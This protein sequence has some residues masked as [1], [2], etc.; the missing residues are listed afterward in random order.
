MKTKIKIIIVVIISVLMVAG[1][2]FFAINSKKETI[3]YFNADGYLINNTYDSEKSKINKEYFN[4]NAAY[5]S[6]SEDKY[7][8]KNTDGENVV[9]SEES[10]VH[11]SDGSIMAL[12]DG[13]AID[14]DKIDLEILNYY[15]IFDG[16]ILSKKDNT[17]EINNLNDTIVFNKMLFKI[18]DNKYLLA[19]NDIVISFADGQTVSTQDYIEIEYANEDV[20]KIYNDKV[21]YKTISSNLYIICDNI[22][23]DVAYKTVSKNNIDLLA[24]VN[25][26]INANDNIEV[27]PLKD[28]SQ[29]QNDEGNNSGGSGSGNDSSGNGGIDIDPGIFDNPQNNTGNNN[30]NGDSG[31]NEVIDV[32]SIINPGNSSEN[33]EPVF[34]QPKFNFS[35]LFISTVSV[36]FTIEYDDPS[37]VLAGDMDVEIVENS[38]GEVIELEPWIRENE[39]A[40]FSYSAS[41]VNLNA[42]SAYTINVRGQYEVD[43]K[44]F[45]RVFVSKI[46]RTNDLGLEIYTDY[47]TSDDLKFVVERKETSDVTGFDYSILEK[48]TKPVCTGSVSNYSDNEPNHVMFDTNKA[49]LPKDCGQFLSNTDYTLE[50]YNF[51]Y[52]GARNAESTLKESYTAKTLRS[53]SFLS[54]I[55]IE[56]YI[57]HSTSS[58]V[59]TAENIAP[60]KSAGIVSYTYK[61]FSGV[62]SGDNPDGEVE[63]VEPLIVR[64]TDGENKVVFQLDELRETNI[65]EF[66][67]QLEIK[68][69]DNEKTIIRRYESSS[70]NIG[71][72]KYPVV[73]DFKKA[74]TGKYYET[75]SGLI[76]LSY[77]EGIVNGS[78]ISDYRVVLKEKNE[79]SKVINY[80]TVKSVING[81]EMG[82]PVKFENLIPCTAEG[83][84]KEY[85]LFVYVKPYTE[86]NYIYIGYE[87]V[88]MDIPDVEL[89]VEND[90]VEGENFFSSQVTL[91]ESESYKVLDKLKFE[92][93]ACEGVSS[94]DRTG[95]VA[96]WEKKSDELDFYINSS[97]FV[98][99][100]HG[101]LYESAIDPHF[102]YQ[103]IISA[104]GENEN[105]SYPIK[106]NQTSF[107][108]AIDVPPV[109][110][111]NITPTTYGTDNDEGYQPNTINGY[112]FKFAVKNN[113]K[114]QTIEEVEY[115]I[116]KL[117]QC[118]TENCLCENLLNYIINEN[119]DVNL[120]I[121]ESV[122]PEGFKYKFIKVGSIG[123]GDED[124]PGGYNAATSLT[125]PLDDDN[126]F[127]RGGT[128]CLVYSGDVKDSDPGD[129]S[130]DKVM[131][132]KFL[133]PEKEK[134]ILNNGY[135][136]KYKTCESGDED[137]T[138]CDSDKCSQLTFKLDFVNKDNSGSFS[139]VG[140]NKDE[141]DVK[142]NQKVDC[143]TET[144]T[145]QIEGELSNDQ[146][147]EL[148]VLQ[149]KY[150]PILNNSGEAKYLMDDDVVSEEKYEFNLGTI[151]SAIVTDPSV[152]KIENGLVTF[153]L[154]VHGVP[155]N[156]IY[157]IKLNSKYYKIVKE[158]MKDQGIQVT[159]SIPAMAFDIVDGVIDFSKENN[160]LSLVYDNNQIELDLTPGSQK[161]Y[162]LTKENDSDIYYSSLSTH[163]ALYIEDSIEFKFKFNS[164]SENVFSTAE[165]SFGYLYKDKYFVHPHSIVEQTLVISNIEEV[166]VV[167]Y[168]SSIE[169]KYGIS[170]STISF[171]TNLTTDEVTS[172][173]QICDNEEICYSI[174]KSKVEE[175]AGGGLYSSKVTLTFFKKTIY[176]IKYNGELTLNYDWGTN[177]DELEIDL[178][179]NVDPRVYIQ[180]LEYFKNNDNKWDNINGT[181]EFKNMLTIYFDFKEN[182]ISLKNGEEIT[183]CPVYKYNEQD[184]TLDT[185]G[186]MSVVSDPSG[187][188]DERIVVNISKMNEGTNSI[189]LMLSFTG[190]NTPKYIYAD[191]KLNFIKEEP[192]VDVANPSGTNFDISM[193]D[194]GGKLTSCF[195]SSGDDFYKN[196]WND[197]TNHTFDDILSH[198]K[199][200][201]YI[202]DINKQIAKDSHGNMYYVLLEKG[203][204]L[205]SFSAIPFYAE[206][207][208]INWYE[209]FNTYPVLSGDVNVK[210]LYCT[211]ETSGTLV[212]IHQEGFNITNTTGLNVNSFIGINQVGVSIKNVIPDNIISSFAKVRYQ[213]MDNTG[214]LGN[215][216]EYDKNLA[217]NIV[218]TNGADWVNIG[219]IVSDPTDISYMTIELL[220]EGGNLYKSLAYYKQ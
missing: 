67:V 113:L 72:E 143:E 160:Q 85:N 93:Y 192:Q 21:N 25:M 134:L 158:K 168:T 123:L 66:R 170:E 18:S 19:A 177:N 88:Q 190:V 62:V 210:V 23:I 204:V 184:P 91:T 150:S 20:I 50:L 5:Q 205:Y 194:R 69:D 9:V 102:S 90:S 1:G 106:L 78:P 151:N 30:S 57:D 188:I 196:F 32:P 55:Y 169:T 13:V 200:F 14:L 215:Y 186:C 146:T 70:I 167:P 155:S 212:N 87:T 60:D 114:D 198:Q 98:S 165:D 95:Y 181:I 112:E 44:T 149:E 161:E 185:D 208:T 132:A 203:D 124:V 127:E 108:P 176:S 24:M 101:P 15:N 147:L 118:D 209:I 29:E 116:F 187:T 36:S 86:T 8:F 89:K 110:D 219:I 7:S 182:N 162:F 35:K 107:D 75:I 125:I 137:C 131:N 28:D 199:Y 104:Y 109:L 11:Y 126:S 183:I 17:Y 51:Y 115:K 82:I 61:I 141:T 94:C 142:G 140:F 56:D 172:N 22:K 174:E 157:G 201:A 81:S 144:C 197:S 133:R 40:P 189:G 73:V 37:E 202:Q 129:N 52:N 145:F 111:V 65:D 163:E 77:D 214:T 68:F 135:L 191:N 119:P 122:E 42:N 139:I 48:G 12:K 97:D 54:R 16:S 100:L 34:T 71:N 84:A 2:L 216:H 173:L 79:P 217:Q 4:A 63:N 26:V 213:A 121:G 3:K 218:V 206:T 154:T 136:Q 120:E 193:I 83:I 117:T 152:Q 105:G 41:Y 6:Q 99:D 38:T 103:I 148:S 92:L 64:E 49:I 130:K 171:K 45:D 39:I 156:K 53:S 175:I 27:V 96:L 180:N 220:D 80:E 43:G 166:N 128:Y 153:A 207:V 211:K 58:L 164:T 47:V 74:T 33:E 46:F 159:F 59:L 76:Q 10:F 179:Q 138:G 195:G 178:L 31:S